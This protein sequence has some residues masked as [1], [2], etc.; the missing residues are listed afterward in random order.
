MK[1]NVAISVLL[2]ALLAICGCS[3]PQKQPALAPAVS[4]IQALTAARLPA[5]RSVEP[6]P[7]K[8]GD[9]LVFTTDHYRIRTTLSDV[10]ILR[11]LPAFMESAYRGYQRELPEAIETQNKF[12][13]Y[14]FE[15]RGQWEEF[16]DDFAGTSAALYKRIQKGAYCF[17]GA[18][19]AYYIGRNETYS[20]I[21]HEGWHQFSGRHFAYRLPSWLDEGIAT[22]FETGAYKGS[23]WVFE[24]QMNVGRLAGLKLTLQNG[25]SI[26]IRQLIALNPGE[27]IGGQD[28]TIAFYSESYALVRFLRE[29]QYGKR[30]GQYHAMLLGGLRGTWPLTE[31]AKRIAADRNIPLTVRWNQYAGPA[32][33][34]RYIGANW[35]QLEQEYL[36]FARK[37]TFQIRLREPIP[38]D[39][40]P[41]R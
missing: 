19:V 11:M 34:E 33:F 24:P 8:Y 38:T 20:A 37:V 28:G 12:D 31:E 16:S 17:Q 25:N 4:P 10:L 18:C 30:L 36:V 22:L 3:S 9:G 41:P 40:E 13:V 15:N 1:K 2:A 35:D 39:S 32:L 7:N 23:E 26:P 21:G 14:L 5:I 6:W 27:V 29:E